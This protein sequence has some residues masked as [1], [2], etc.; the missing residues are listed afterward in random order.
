MLTVEWHY[1][2]IVRQTYPHLVRHL[3]LLPGEQA[4]AVKVRV[5]APSRQYALGLALYGLNA[6]STIGRLYHPSPHSIQ[7]WHPRNLA[8]RGLTEQLPKLEPYRRLLYNFH[9][10]ETDEGW[11]TFNVPS[12][13][14]EGLK[15]RRYNRG[16]EHQWWQLSASG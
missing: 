15:L 11:V 16:E 12:S 9:P 10:G 1:E 7:A 4:V 5:T 2:E 6:A 14:I 3:R 8:E 13:E